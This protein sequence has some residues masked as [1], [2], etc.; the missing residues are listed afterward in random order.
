MSYLATSYVWMPKMDVAIVELVHQCP[1]GQL[2]Q[3]TPTKAPLRPGSCPDAPWKS[4]HADFSYPFLRKMFWQWKML[5]Q[6]GSKLCQRANLAHLQLR[7]LG[8]VQFFEFARRL[9]SS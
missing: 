9:W 5:I 7:Q 1:S 3:K 6:N 8:S 2:I 4:V